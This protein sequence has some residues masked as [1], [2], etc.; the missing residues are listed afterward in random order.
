MPLARRNVLFGIAALP[1]SSLLGGRPLPGLSLTVFNGYELHTA[2]QAAGSGPSILLAPGNYGD[3]GRF[4]L[5]NSGVSIRVQSPLRTI[6][7]AP[8]EV[9]GDRVE[10]EGLTFEARCP[11]RRHRPQGRQQRPQQRA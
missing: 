3:V 11:S 9:R 1:A 4:T 2:L 8:L 5:A 7:R 6:L 10:L